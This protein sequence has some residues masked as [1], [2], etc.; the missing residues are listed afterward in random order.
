MIKDASVKKMTEKSIASLDQLAEEVE[1]R[2]RAERILHKNEEQ[3]RSIVENFISGIFIA[4]GDGRI[5]YLNGKACEIFGYSRDEMIG[6]N[7]QEYF[8]EEG[9][10]STAHLHNRRLTGKN[11]E[12]PQSFN[13]VTKNDKKRCVEAS[14]TMINAAEEKQQTIVQVLDI[15][16]KKQLTDHLQ[17]VQKIQAI[18]DMAGG[19]AHQFNNALSGIVGNVDLIEMVFAGNRKLAGYTKKIKECSQRMTQLT[20][21]L[22]AYARSEKY[23][24][25]K[26]FLR[27]LIRD[28]LPLIKHAI[29]PAIKIEMDW[30][31]N[32]VYINGDMAQIQMVLMAVLANASEAIEDKG[33][34]QIT[35]IHEII[36]DAAIIRL[37]DLKPGDYLR[38][39]VRDNGKGMNEE[40]RKRIFDPFFTT[41]FIGRG[42][43]MAAVY[44]IIKNHAGGI[45]VESEPGQGTTV[46]IYLPT[47]PAFPKN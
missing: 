39:S 28:T 13:I 36:T 10:Q 29:N 11:S 4:D 21:Q 33:H 30:P 15:T 5:I 14:A 26:L 42:L 9:K 7:F 43:G 34:I 31:T 16:D 1:K 12:Q 35:L 19:I 44:G 38:L 20:S 32:N 18:S 37:P 46:K 23:Q 47:I 41:R 8:T 45:T 27:D 25:E 24:P 40:A 6:R 17:Q 3:F 22:L 2:T